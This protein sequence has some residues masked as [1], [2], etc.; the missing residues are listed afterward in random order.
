MRKFRL[1]KLSAEATVGRNWNGFPFLDTVYAV[2][3]DFEYLDK[4]YGG[5]YG[6]WD[7]T[8]HY[9]PQDSYR[10]S[11]MFTFDFRQ[12]QSLARSGYIEEVDL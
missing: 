9:F 2:Y 12:F 4:N 8:V 3:G 1:F 6:P 7:V 5:T 10:E 11:P